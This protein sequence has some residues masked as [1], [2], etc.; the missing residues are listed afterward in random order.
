[1]R[2]FYLLLAIVGAVV[3]YSQFL[4]WFMEHGPNIPLL[5]NQLFSTRIGAFFGFDVL[6]SA[7]VVITFVLRDGPRDKVP[8]LWLP[9]VATCLVGVSCGLPLFLYL[10]ENRRS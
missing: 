10:R 9:I 4:P 8:M 5:V 2:Y 1:M 3:P 7:V 6:I